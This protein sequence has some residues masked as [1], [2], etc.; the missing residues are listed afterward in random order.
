MKMDGI[1]NYWLFALICIFI[2][3]YT[4]MLESFMLMF[5][6]YV[7]YASCLDIPIY[8]EIKSYRTS[9]CPLHK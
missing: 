8:N 2:V 5:K 4:F 6:P 1:V 7:L 9:M 3:E